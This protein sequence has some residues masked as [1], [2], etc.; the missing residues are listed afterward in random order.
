MRHLLLHVF[1]FYVSAPG[2]PAE[3]KMPAWNYRSWMTFLPSCLTI[4][5]WL[6]SGGQSFLERM[7]HKKRQSTL[8]VVLQRGEQTTCSFWG[9]ESP[10]PLPPVLTA[11]ILGKSLHLSRSFHLSWRD[12]PEGESSRDGEMH[13]THWEARSEPSE[14]PTPWVACKDQNSQE[15]S[16]MFL[17]LQQG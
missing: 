2:L 7:T 10:I 13:L 16:W 12:G 6:A 8:K 4:W 9:K 11:V 5:C 15:R 1:I 17:L 14:R 3:K